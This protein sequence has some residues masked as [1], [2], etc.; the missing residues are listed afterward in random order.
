M[1]LGHSLA[2]LGL[3]LSAL[4][5]RAQLAQVDLPQ[6][7]A[8]LLE[9]DRLAAGPAWTDF[10]AQSGWRVADW[11]RFHAYPHRVL[12][13]G[14]ELPG[15]PIADGADLDRRLRAFLEAH[16]GLLHGG[17]DAQLKDLQARHVERHGQV[18]YANYQQTWKGQRVE[19]AELVFRVSPA[20]RLLLAGS[21][22]H[23]QIEVREPR[24]S[25]EQALAAARGL[26]R[27][28]AVRAVEAADWVVLPRLGAKG[29]EY[30]SAWPVRVVLDDPEQIW[31]VFLDGANGDVLWSWNE[32]RHLQVE[33]QLQGLLEEQQPSDP[34]SP[35]ALP[36]LRFSFD[37]Q[38]VFADSEGYFSLETSA[39]PPWN[40]TGALDGRFADVQRQDG[41]DGF[42]SLLMDASGQVL[43]VG[44][45]DAQVVEL[46]AYHHTTRVHD[47]ITDMDPS[48]T[49]LDEPLTVRVNIAE[50]CNAYW[51]GS[52]INFFQEGGGCP[53]TGRVAGVVYHEYGHGINDRQ[54]RQAGAPWG[55]TNGAMHEGLA[56]VTSIYLQDEHYVA[57]GWNIRELDNDQRYPE[58]IQGEVH[59]DGEIIGG[60]MYDLRQALGLEAVRPLHH[61]ARWG[62]P[63]DADLG[64]AGFEYFLELLVVDD[65]DEDLSNLTPHYPEINAAFNLHGIGS[66]LAWMSTDFSLGDP[67]QTWAP[68]ETL[69]LTATLSAPAFVTPDAV[70]LL[71]WVGEETPQSLLLELQADG[72]WT[73]ALPGQPWNTVLQYYAR[74]QNSAGVE[75]TSPVGAPEQVFR[76]RFVW[77]AGLTESFEFAPGGETLNEVWQWGEPQDGPG[78]AFDGA[79]CWGTNLTGNYP[80]MNLS[81]LVLAE[82][83]VDD[84][85]QV[86]VR[87]RHWLS[88]EEGWDGVNVEYALN[89]SATYN[90]LTPLS[91]YDFNTP[92]NN[93]LPFTPALTGASAGW[94]SLVFDLTEL[95]APGDRV[96]LRLN[97]FSDTSVT[98]AGWYVDLLEYL[99]FAAPSQI[100]HE[101]LGDSEDGAQTGFPVEARV[102]TPAA[103]SRFDL[104]YRVDGGALQTLPMQAGDDGHVAVIPGPFWEQTIEYRLEA[105]GEGGFVAYLPA[106]P[107]EWF[108]FRV[109]ADQTPPAVSFLQAPTDAAGWTALWTVDVAAEDNLD[110]PLARVWLEW[111]APG[112]QWAELA[113]LQE[114]GPGRFSGHVDFSP[115][116]QLPVVELRALARDASTQQWEAA[117]AELALSLGSEQSIAT[118]EQPLLPDWSMEGVFTAQT[119]RVHSGDYALGSGEDGFYEPG[120][121]GRA[122]WTGSLDLRQVTDPALVLWETWFLENGDDEAWIEVSPDGG[123][124]WSLLATRTNGRGWLETRLSLAPWVGVADLK[125][126]IGFQADGDSDGLHIGYFADD[127]RLVNQSGVAVAEPAPLTRSFQ[128]GEPWPNP[129]NPVSH[130]EVHNPNGLPLTLT[131]HNLLG[132]EVARLHDGPLPAGTRQFRV[133][134]AGLAS[135]LYLLTARQGDQQ[136]V[137]RLLLV[138]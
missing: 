42:F 90:L 83:Q 52:S 54:Y 12:G 134:G 6:A 104:L 48:F 71:Y 93:V 46:D 112:G 89:G 15:G 59:Y 126:R 28:P 136:D 116:Q 117:T 57:P 25:R 62:T 84:E 110:L 65:D 99:G 40:V 101:A 128:L 44:L 47:F 119:T 27:T 2:L 107:A 94:E 49:G 100:E 124:E 133:D 23:G 113:D 68:S 78:A 85:D 81:R 63:D 125:L 70:E 66:V 16:P 103:L 33:G 77:N 105:Q 10:A 120:S 121:T 123:E 56:D 109:G 19:E 127:I 122:T 41:A 50:T 55:M 95:T 43:T 98:E 132:Q 69:P 75:I 92:D 135:G 53:N 115:G 72:T 91:G 7:Q 82:Q 13:P 88:V 4:T 30:R 80:D 39:T 74:V 18:W 26:S 11:D 37:G 138:R 114:E 130:V 118:F 76:T 31:R 86:I 61:F 58:D 129:F 108:Q 22:L 67:P 36:H 111:R 137:R 14:L 45:E 29:Y 24:L 32:V 34:D 73:G 20:G 17:R 131:L 60:A 1:R 106:N 87:F 35:H 51:D 79:L 21:D 97:L 38:E 96:R 3:S 9:Q 102:N 8:R 64:R 5:A